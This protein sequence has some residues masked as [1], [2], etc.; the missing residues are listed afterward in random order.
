MLNSAHLCRREKRTTADAMLSKLPHHVRVGGNR[1]DEMFAIVDVEAAAA[2][3]DDD[4]DDKDAAEPAANEWRAVL[5]EFADAAP[6]PERANDERGD[7]EL[8]HESG[9]LK[10]SD[11]ARAAGDGGGPAVGGGT[12]VVVLVVPLLAPRGHD[13][14]RHV[15]SRHMAFGTSTRYHAQNLEWRGRERSLISSERSSSG[16]TATTTM[17][18]GLTRSHDHMIT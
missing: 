9:C 2:A 1:S 11:E 17:P 15:I 10:L 3:P 4:D 5:E 13:R 18:L 14:T 16:G 12:R 7:G 6:A 8:P